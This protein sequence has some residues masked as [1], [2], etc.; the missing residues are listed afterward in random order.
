MF[1]VKIKIKFI[2]IRANNF[3]IKRFFLIKRVQK[4]LEISQLL[5]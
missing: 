5:G 3:K 2:N 4:F 1:V